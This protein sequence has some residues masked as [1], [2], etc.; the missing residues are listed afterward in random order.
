MAKQ[1]NYASWDDDNKY[2]AEDI[3]AGASASRR[4]HEERKEKNLKPDTSLRSTTLDMSQQSP[5]TAETIPSLK[6]TESVTKV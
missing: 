3:L 6:K 2:N 1:N 5:S 4:K